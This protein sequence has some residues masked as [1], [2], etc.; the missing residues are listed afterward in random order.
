LDLSIYIH[1][2]FCIRKCYYCDLNSHVQ[3]HDGEEFT[4]KLIK[5]IKYYQRMHPDFKVKTIFFGGGTPSLMKAE[6]IASVIKQV[7]HWRNEIQE[8]TIEANPTN[9]ECIKLLDLK[10]AGIDRIS[11]GVQSFD[12]T[13]LKSLGRNHTSSDAISM[14]TQAQ[15]IFDKISLDLM[16]GLPN[17]NL[18]IMQQ[19]LDQFVKL[20]IK[21]LSI[22]SLT[23]EKNTAFGQMHL[24]NKLKLPSENLVCDMYDLIVST[25]RDV[26][27]EQYEIS[28]F[29]LPGH[30]SKHNLV[31]WR[32][33][34]W[35]GIG[36]GAHSRF[37]YNDNTIE[38]ANI[39]S[40]NQWLENVESYGRG[41][42]SEGIV[43]K[44]TALEEEL[45]MKL[46]LK[47]G[48]D[49][50]DIAK[51]FPNSIKSKLINLVNTGD[52]IGDN[53]GFHLTSK[54]FLRYNA[55]L[56]YIY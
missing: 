24:A 5:E 54:G 29:A 40:P 34:N 46:R 17:Q 13:I 4:E 47:E 48:L 26:G 32:Y 28:N 14:V 52:I 33:G 6:W 3:D 9:G 15:S 2:P 11:F 35:I 7:C 41:N 21:H 22:Y 12:N 56:K 18:D 10:E 39:K 20:N 19:S 38:V 25:M 49:K 50:Q 31:Y 30:E 53:N 51:I 42:E 16:Y 45:I 8:V 43:D 27:L 44:K 37:R 1:W 23:I 55:V 36:P